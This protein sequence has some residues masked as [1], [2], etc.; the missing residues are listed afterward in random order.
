MPG[1]LGFRIVQMI[2][3]LSFGQDR[4]PFR[5]H[6]PPEYLQG[7]RTGEPIRG[8]QI[9]LPAELTVF[10]QDFQIEAWIYLFPDQRICKSKEMPLS[11]L[12]SLCSVK[13]I[14]KALSKMAS[15]FCEPSH[16]SNETIVRGS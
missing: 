5:F 1:I 13:I 11:V 7:F 4:P 8:R 10:E 9:S 14:D 6:F 15:A 12:A 2:R 3:P 16:V